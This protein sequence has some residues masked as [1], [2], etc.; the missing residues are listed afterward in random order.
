[1]YY[2]IFGF[3]FGFIIPYMARRFA[4][5]MPATPAYAV[6][7]LIKPHA[8]VSKRKKLSN[9]QYQK[10]CRRYFMRSLGWAIVCAALSWLT[11]A[12]L[13]QYGCASIF[14]TG[15]LWTL[16]LLSE[17]DTRMYILPDILT[18]P[19][20]L[21]GFLFSV[22]CGFIN[23]L[24]SAL[25]SL[26]GFFLPVIASA[27]LVWKDKN[28]LGGGDIKLFSAIGAWMGV[29]LLLY[30]VILSSFLFGIASIL[31]RQRSG[32]FGPSI[33]LATIIVAFWVFSGIP[34]KLN[35]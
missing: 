22:T 6:Y 25:A 7:R 2:A 15:F 13:E 3:L 24:E 8:S 11:K 16:L 9:P 17:I 28:A 23:P 34:Y 19:L 29:E 4:K 12:G 31:K 20:L 10:L 5:F 30:V 1:M 27:F 33:V 32:A 18:F 26:V 35:F 14:C 21:F